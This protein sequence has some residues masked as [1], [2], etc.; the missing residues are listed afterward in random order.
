MTKLTEKAKE[1]GRILPASATDAAKA[2]SNLGSAGFTT[3]EIMQSVEGTLY[4]ATAAQTD[5]AT[6]ADITSSTLRGFG[7]EA[8]K[9]GHVSDVLALT[10]AKT[11]AGI[12]DL[13]EGMKYASPVMKSMGISLEETSA[14]MGILANA[15]IKGSQ[16]GTTLRTAMVRLTKPMKPAIKAMT[17]LGFSA[18]D[19]KGKMK[20][21]ATTIGE[22]NAKTKNLTVQQKNQAIAQIFG[23][24]S[25]SGMLALMA[26]GPTQINGLTTA[27]KGADGAAA[28][29]AETQT[30]NLY[31][32]LQSIDGAF[33]T[34]KINIG[35]KAAPAITAALKGLA[36]AVPAM[37]AAV[38]GGMNKLFDFAGSVATTVQPTLVSL[39][40]FIMTEMVPRFKDI[41][42][43]MS[44]L[45]TT[46][47][48][49]LGAAFDM[50][51]TSAAAVVT[52]GLDLIKGALTWL[53]DN[54]GLTAIV[55]TTVGIAFG[56]YGV[57]VGVAAAATAY[58]NV[59]T[60]IAFVKN[61]LLLGVT[62]ALKAA[63]LVGA[64]ATGVITAAQWLWNAAMTANPIGLV[65][66]AVVGL[67]AGIV[68]AYNHF[69]T[70][71]NIVNGVWDVLK[72]F[73]GIIFKV[74]KAMGGFI[75][76][77]AGFVTGADKVSA[78]SDKA[79]S[80]ATNTAI[81]GAHT[82]KNANGTA[83][84]GGGASLV[85]ERGGEMQLLRNG[86]G[87]IPAEKTDRLLKGD[88]S[89]G[90]ITNYFTIDASGMD[91]DEL[92][93]KLQ[94]RMKNM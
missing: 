89:N 11:N 85:N 13:G 83:Y 40:D 67:V 90:G 74:G 29:M 12:L 72:G 91:A 52:G 58:H 53:N 30:D 17:A 19:S 60:G 43:T 92:I 71:R 7:L 56:I 33:E 28:K 86:T 3:N 76:K 88:N 8:A 78:A 70:F 45:Y 16:G 39:K 15:G 26:A 51:K 10:A 9:S 73:L 77:V 61:M 32:A 50:I 87:I 54:S 35:E 20:P 44:E 94:I 22:L 48:P 38:M 31:G 34:L 47:S 81:K 1:M 82:D 2:M 25:L 69:T 5:M 62:T 65:V 4:L 24:E 14:A 66:L 93:T 49:L 41:G 59:V 6:A 80:A 55:L 23:T 57:T 21:L 79:N 18:Y 37:G 46:Y 84:F 68:I 42:I 64:V 75:S 63:Q 27:L 36:G